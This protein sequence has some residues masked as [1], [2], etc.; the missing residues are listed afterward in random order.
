M[1]TVGRV[2]FVFVHFVFVLTVYT[3]NT[4]IVPR[5]FSTSAHFYEILQAT[6]Y[7]LLMTSYYRASFSLAGPNSKMKAPEILM[8]DQLKKQCSKCRAWKPPRAHHC[9]TCQKCIFRMDHHCEWVNNC[10]GSHNQ[11]YFMLFLFYTFLIS[12]VTLY[13]IIIGAIYWG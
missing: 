8:C 11:K 5:F 1:F 2:L 7:I 10:V 13:L 6:L 9:K 3:I 4:V 12:L